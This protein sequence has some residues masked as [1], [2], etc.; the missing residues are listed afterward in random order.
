MN[1]GIKPCCMCGHHEDR[2]HVLTCKSLDTELIRADSWIKLKK[3]M[4]KWSLPSDMWIDM[5]NG[6]RHYTMNPL[7]RD[8]ENMPPEPLSPFGTTFY[9]PRNRLKV[10]F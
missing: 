9:T 7:K 10:A 3:Q 4:Y 2:R 5:E 6:V 8:A 1:C